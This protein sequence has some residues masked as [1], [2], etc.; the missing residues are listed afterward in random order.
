M[1][2]KGFGK[3][4]DKMVSYGIVKTDIR[5]QTDD[6]ETGAKSHIVEKECI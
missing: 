5:F 2:C 3:P 6:V 1:T 4:V